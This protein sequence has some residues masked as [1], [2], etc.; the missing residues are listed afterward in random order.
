LS[1]P[2]RS[3]INMAQ[4][5]FAP[6]P[7]RINKIVLKGAET[8]HSINDKETVAETRYLRAPPALADNPYVGFDVAFGGKA[9]MAHCSANVRF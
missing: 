6:R 5:F 9:D 1:E 3:A 4:T 8:D 2:R 7:H